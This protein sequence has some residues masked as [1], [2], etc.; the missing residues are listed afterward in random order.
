M[1]FLLGILLLAVVIGYAVGG[2]LRRVEALRLRW[3]WLAPLGLAMQL[4]PV[5]GHNLAVGLLIASYPVLLAFAFGNI[6]LAGFALIFVGLALN[7]TVIA[8]NQGMPV[9]RHA[10]VASGQGSLL[11]DLEHHGGAKHFL[12]RPGNTVLLPLGDVIAIGDPVNQVV[13]IGDCVVY[14][15]VVWLIVAAMRGRSVLVSPRP[16]E[17]E[18]VR[19]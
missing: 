17:D 2:R 10:L 5:S 13:S 4:I 19:S 15:G 18:P 12:A 3:W 14:A 7:L 11:G 16:R 8:A 6:R 1:R 9:T